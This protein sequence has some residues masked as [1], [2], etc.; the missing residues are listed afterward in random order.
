MVMIFILTILTPADNLAL[1]GAIFITIFIIFIITII[2]ILLMIN[3]I[4][5]TDNLG[6]PGGFQLGNTGQTYCD[7]RTATGRNGHQA[8]GKGHFKFKI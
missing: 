7:V 6:L 4:T 8:R 2:I 5:P 3:F 1:P